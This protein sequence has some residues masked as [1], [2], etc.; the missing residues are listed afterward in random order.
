MKHNK[1]FS[2][3]KTFG[4]F[5]IILLICYGL[6][7]LLDI[8][9]NGVFLDWSLSLFASWTGLKAFVIYGFV[10][11]VFTLSI[12]IWL[13]LH[14]HS[15]RKVKKAVRQI[16]DYMRTYWNSDAALPPMA[17]QFAEIEA[18]LVQM[19]SDAVKNEQMLQAEAQRKND[20]ITYLAHDLKTPLASVIGYL[21][22]LDEAKDLPPQ[23]R[24]KYT[25]VAL[26][27]A[28]RL[29]QLINEFFD[30][31]RFNLQTIVVNDEKINL[32]YML[33]QMADEFYPILAPQG[34]FA[35][36]YAQEQLVIWGDADKLARVFNNILKNAVAYSYADSEISIIAY[37]KEHFVT[38][39]FENHGDPI[40]TQKLDTIFEKFYRLDA[41]RSS[42]TGGA[43]LGLAIAKEIVNAHGGRITAES[44]VEKTAFTVQLPIKP[45]HII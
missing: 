34:K 33:R 1:L 28:Y 45:N 16:T 41:S 5:L 8:V 23:Q 26:E 3:L 36:V 20:L 19:K 29:E 27:K 44:N 38:I 25:G 32:T 42:Q 43:G 10:I 12:I 4:I 40:P 22:L 11:F 14:F 18:L 13:V 9:F 15:R 35:T 31:I 39:I 24:Q 17:S 30:I 21:N 7:Y 37:G 6:I 2:V